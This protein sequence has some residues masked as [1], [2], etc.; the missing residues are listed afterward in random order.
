MIGRENNSC[1]ILETA[2]LLSA[3]FESL[4]INYMYPVSSH[5][6][7]VNWSSNDWLL[8]ISNLVPLS[9]DGLIFSNKED[10]YKEEKTFHFRMSCH[11]TA[12]N[13][14]FFCFK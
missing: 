9:E 3:V 12:E 7:L 6:T 8:P 2:K 5:E 13:A 11:Y 10:K 14:V 4:S 1:H